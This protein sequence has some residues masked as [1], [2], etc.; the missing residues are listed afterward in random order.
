MK[1]IKRTVVNSD[2]RQYSVQLVLQ[3]DSKPIPGRLRLRP[4]KILF[5]EERV[6][7]LNDRYFTDIRM[8]MCPVTVSF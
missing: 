8:G 2:V 3:Y 6:K 1:E 5:F 4:T 7:C